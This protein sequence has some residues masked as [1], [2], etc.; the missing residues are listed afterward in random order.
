MCDSFGNIQKWEQFC[1][2][3]QF[4]M[5]PEWTFVSCGA[6]DVLRLVAAVEDDGVEAL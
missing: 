2:F 6:F 1:H 5:N 4:D 3:S